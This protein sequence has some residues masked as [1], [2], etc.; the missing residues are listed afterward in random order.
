MKP[1][2]VYGVSL[3]SIEQASGVSREL[4][5]IESYHQAYETAKPSNNKAS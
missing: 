4:E 3:R 2:E 5:V 1:N